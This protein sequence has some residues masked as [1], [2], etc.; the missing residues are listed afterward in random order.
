MIFHGTGT[1]KT[2]AAIAIAEKFKNQVQ[3][4]GTQIYVL[5]PGPLLKESW[6]E[7]FIKCTGETYLRTHENLLFLNDEEKEKIKKQAVLNAQQYYKIMSYRSFYRKVLGEKISE[8]TI[9]EGKIKVKFKKTEYGEFERDIG[10]NILHNL[11]NS[12]IIVDEAHNLTNNSQGEALMKIIKNSINLRVVLL[13]ATPMKNLGHDI[14]ELLNFVRPIDSPIERDL[15]FNSA[16]NHTMELKPGGLEYFKNMAHGYISHL[17]G[18]D[19]MTFAE[20]IEMGIKPKGL[21]FTKICQC[22][23]EKF[24]L[25]AYYEAK[26]LAIEEADAL[27]RKSEAVA[28]FVFPALDESRKKLIG[29]YG[30]E[31]LNKLKNQLKNNYEKINNIKYNEKIKNNEYNPI[32]VHFFLQ[33]RNLVETKS[34]FVIF[35]YRVGQIAYNAGQLSIF[36]EIDNINKDI[37][38]FVIKNNMLDINTYITEDIQNEISMILNQH[39]IDKIIYNINNLINQN[40]GNLSSNHNNIYLQKYLKYKEKYINLKNNVKN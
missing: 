23:M 24:Q 15:I 13:T 1:G 8:K 28:N 34:K 5:V 4:Y 40:G 22:F 25:E 17:R 7:H 35:L 30:R 19:P 31:G 33:L 27:D 9:I 16:K 20:K 21:I 3:R 2:C 39:N 37:K 32:S 11:S 14:I 6:K 36:I 38:D 18:A 26:K 29:L 10:M 12:L